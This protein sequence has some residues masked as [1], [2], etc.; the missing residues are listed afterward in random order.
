MDWPALT[1]SL[2]LSALTVLFLLPVGIFLGRGLAFHRFRGRGLCE[3]LLALPLV[4][5]PTVIGFYLLVTFGSGSPLGQGWRAVFGH[6]LAFSFEGLLLASILINLPFAVQP[7]QRGFEAIPTDVREAAAVTGMPPWRVLWLI[8][9]PLAWPGIVTGLVLAFAHTLGEFGVVLMVGGSIPGET[10]TIAIAIYDRVQAFDTAAAGAM[11]ALLL[12]ISLAAL[13]VTYAL[14][15]R[16][17]R[18]V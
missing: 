16:V 7:M 15:A 2:R 11:S 14:S 10:R 18:R 17:G 3:S 8:D 5:P 13:G 9:L 1:L 4:L 6:P 12:L